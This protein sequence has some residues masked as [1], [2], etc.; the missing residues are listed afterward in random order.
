MFLLTS[1][2]RALSL[3]N[4]CIG[5]FKRGKVMYGIFLLVEVKLTH[6]N[7]FEVYVLNVNPCS[8]CATLHALLDDTSQASSIVFQQF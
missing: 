8:G 3:T 1:E 5:M 4:F 7:K 2:V 6:D